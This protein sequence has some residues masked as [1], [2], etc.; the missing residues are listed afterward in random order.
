MNPPTCSGM[1]SVG[2]DLEAD[3]AADRV[4]DRV[5]DPV[6]AEHVPQASPPSNS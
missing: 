6:A 3:R 5:A 1:P 2:E 4:A